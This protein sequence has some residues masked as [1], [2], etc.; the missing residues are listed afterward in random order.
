MARARIKVKLR[1]PPSPA[2]GRGEKNLRLLEPRDS[3][4]LNREEANQCV[5]CV[6]PC[7][8]GEALAVRGWV[9]NDEREPQTVI[10]AFLEQ[11][12]SDARAQI[13][14]R[15]RQIVLEQ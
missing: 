14:K 7:Q 9:W 2:C 8:F 13:E 5:A 4:R 3:I 12:A 11:L 1:S 10:R 6:F 15:W